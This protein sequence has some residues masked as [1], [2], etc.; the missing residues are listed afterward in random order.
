MNGSAKMIEQ[1]TEFHSFYFCTHGTVGSLERYFEPQVEYIDSLLTMHPNNTIVWAKKE[2]KGTSHWS[3]VAPSLT[4]G[5]VEMN[6]AYQVDQY[7]IDTYARNADASLA[8]QIEEREERQKKILGYTVPVDA[9]SYRYYGNQQ[10]EYGNHDKAIELFDLSLALDPHNLNTYWNKAWAFRNLNNVSNA[11]STYKT[12][13][14]LVES[15]QLDLSAE[16]ANRWKKNIK[17]ELDKL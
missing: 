15:G 13:L 3:V 17:E 1:E 14:E 11:I 2:F 7:L 10:S 5:L 12:A 16:S 8:T 6:R 9:A 4:Y